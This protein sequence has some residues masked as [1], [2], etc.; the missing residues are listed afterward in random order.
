MRGPKSPDS[1]EGRIKVTPLELPAPPGFWPQRSLGNLGLEHTQQTCGS[2]PLRS[3]SNCILGQGGHQPILAISPDFCA[4][5]AREL[6]SFPKLCVAL[7]RNPLI[8]RS[9]L[10]ALQRTRVLVAHKNGPPA[11]RGTVQ[12]FGLEH[13]LRTEDNKLRK[14]PC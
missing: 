2:F 14:F 7:I 11:P 9:P 8:F 4:S 1:R 10:G 13:R 12:P 6:I 3:L 5:L